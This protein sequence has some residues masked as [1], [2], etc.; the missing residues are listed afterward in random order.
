MFGW[1]RIYLPEDSCIWAKRSWAQIQSYLREGKSCIC[2]K[3][4]PNDEFI[5]PPFIMTLYCSGQQNCK[6]SNIK[7]SWSF[8]KRS[9][10]CSPHCLERKKSIMLPWHPNVHFVLNCWP[11][12]YKKKQTTWANLFISLVD[13]RLLVVTSPFYLLASLS[14][15]RDDV[16]TAQIQKILGS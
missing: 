3:Q 6:D 5:R 10:L 14:W 13:D 4:M 9:W 8:W 16:T 12:L 11:E 7:I 2:Q 1:Y 15:D